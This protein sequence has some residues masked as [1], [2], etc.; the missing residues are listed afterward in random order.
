MASQPFLEPFVLATPQ[1]PRRREG[2]VDVYEADGGS[3]RRPAVVLVHGGP[4]PDTV[5]PTPRDWPVFVGYASLAASSGLVGVTVDHHLHAP[6]DYPRAQDEVAAAIEQVRGLPEVDPQAVA[7]WFFSGAGPLSARWLPEPPDWLRCV[8]LS[9]PLLATP[10]DW[11][12]AH[13]CVPSRLCRLPLHLSCSPGS[14]GNSRP[15]PPPSPGSWRP[16]PLAA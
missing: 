12:S 7:L 11:A 8:A 1:V 15:S 2:A 4:V 16:R 10:P 14:A 6:S 5:R 13:N 3:G 9:Y